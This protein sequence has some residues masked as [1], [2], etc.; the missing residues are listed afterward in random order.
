MDMCVYVG[1][2]MYVY[3]YVCICMYMYVHV[4][5][6]IYVYIFI[7]SHVF[8]DSGSKAQRAKLVC[9]NVGDC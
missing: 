9:L 8:L 7:Q 1:M 2:C 4:C 3:V 5:I 6:C